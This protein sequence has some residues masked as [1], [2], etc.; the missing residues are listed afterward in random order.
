MPKQRKLYVVE[1]KKKTRAESALNLN[2]ESGRVILVFV[3]SCHE[4][5]RETRIIKLT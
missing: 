2:N 3:T 5:S 4:I 1:W